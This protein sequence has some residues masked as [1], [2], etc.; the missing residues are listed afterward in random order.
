MLT[1]THLTW[2]EARHSIPVPLDDNYNEHINQNYHLQC[3]FY[4]TEW[5]GRP[6]ICQPY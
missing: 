2:L 6:E 5:G 4:G 1:G 3:A